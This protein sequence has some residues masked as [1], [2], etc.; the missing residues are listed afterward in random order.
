MEQHKSTLVARGSQLEA[1][2]K[3]ADA[4][5]ASSASALANSARERDNAV[6]ELGELRKSYDQVCSSK[7]DFVEKNRVLAKQLEA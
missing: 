3:V 7:L 5:R 4:A 6:R 1:D 2:L